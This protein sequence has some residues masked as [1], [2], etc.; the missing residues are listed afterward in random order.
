MGDS[1]TGTVTVTLLFTDLV[2][3]TE[4]FEQIGD[5]KAERL[6]RTHFRLVR[7]AVARH[8]GHEVK[9]RGDG[10]PPPC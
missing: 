9:N 4:R 10:W 2:G 5:D 7:D 8:G 1:H 3:S 6:R